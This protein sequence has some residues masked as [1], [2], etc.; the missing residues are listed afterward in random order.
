MPKAEACLVPPGRL[1]VSGIPFAIQLNSRYCGSGTGRACRRRKRVLSHRAD[2]LFPLSRPSCPAPKQCGTNG[3][4]FFLPSERACT[5]A[6]GGCYKSVPFFSYTF[7]TTSCPAFAVSCPAF[8]ISCPV[9]FGPKV[10][11][12]G[13]S[14]AAFQ[15]NHEPFREFDQVRRLR[16]S[17][18]A[19]I[20]FPL[21]FGIAV[22]CFA[23]NNAQFL[24][25]DSIQ[26]QLKE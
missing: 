16:P 15:A 23:E 2:F 6:G 11:K 19:E 9:F 13:R 20:R 3:T 10:A 17:F 8:A 25:L 18:R 1:P 12:T 24:F 5:R 21:C 7:L 26:C 4:R 14:C 22:H